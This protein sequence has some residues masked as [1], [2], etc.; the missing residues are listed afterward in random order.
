MNISQ[1]SSYLQ[2]SSLQKTANNSNAANSNNSQISAS[3][4]ADGG[5]KKYDFTNISRGELLDTVNNL[6]KSGQMSLDESSSLVMFM[7]PKIGLDGSNIDASDEKVDVFSMLKQSIAFNN[8]I[9]NTT[10]TAY[11]TKAMNFLQKLQGNIFGLD[12]KA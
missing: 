11:D 3:E 5:V 9:G 12:I 10:G 2:A 8:S 1:T 7:G 6:I 4:S